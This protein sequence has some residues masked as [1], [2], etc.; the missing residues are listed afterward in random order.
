MFLK[1]LVNCVDNRLKSSGVETE[2]AGKKRLQVMRDDGSQA[3]VEAEILKKAV[4]FMYFFVSDKT[5]WWIHD[6]VVRKRK[7][8]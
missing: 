1:D 4:D 3:V 7:Q 6:G 2:K 5:C 8:E